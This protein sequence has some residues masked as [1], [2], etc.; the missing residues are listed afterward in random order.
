MVNKRWFANCIIWLHLLGE[1]FLPHCLFVC[2]FIYIRL[3][4]WMPHFSGGFNPLLLIM[5]KLKLSPVL[6]VGTPSKWFLGP[7]VFNFLCFLAVPLQVVLGSST[8]SWPSTEISHLVKELS[9]LKTEKLKMTCRSRV[10]NSLKLQVCRLQYLTFV[11]KPLVL[12]RV[13]LEQKACSLA[14]WP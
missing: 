7:R 6:P 3:D 5:L 13:E 10:S 8:P 1:L 14:L 9:V 2:L 11:E 12:E 4:S